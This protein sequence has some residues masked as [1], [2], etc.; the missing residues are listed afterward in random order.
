MFHPSLEHK[1]GGSSG[2]DHDDPYYGGAVAGGAHDDCK[3]A[4]RDSNSG[5]GSCSVR[6]KED[7]EEID[8]LLSSEDDVVSTGR[9]P[10]YRD[11]SSPHSTCSSSCGGKPRPKKDRMKKMMRT[12]KGIVPGGN[13][14]DTPAVLDEAVRYLKSLKVEAKKLGVRGSDS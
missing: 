11:G 8:A 10:G 6:H 9:T 14:M 3:G 12:L 4:Y 5:D 7:T 13:Q 2:Y 1:L